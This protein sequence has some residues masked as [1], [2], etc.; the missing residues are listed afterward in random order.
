MSEKKNLIGPKVRQLREEKAWTQ[1]ELAA[2]LSKRGWT[3]SVQDL[4]AIEGQNAT[5]SDAQFL[6][7][8]FVL[9]VDHADLF[10][11]DL[12]KQIPREGTSDDT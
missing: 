2:A 11:P 9:E 5:V 10:P 7:L 4:A 8:G 3:C 1:G 6:V 12:A